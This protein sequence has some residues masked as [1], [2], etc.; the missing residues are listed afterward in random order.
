[1]KILRSAL[2]AFFIFSGGHSL[3]ALG[4]KTSSVQNDIS[5]LNAS[6]KATKSEVLYTVHEMVA[7]GNTIK[8]YST[9][10]GV[11][12]AVSWRG[13]SKPDLSVLF[14]S[15]YSEYMETLDEAPKQ[16]GKRNV[17]MKTPRM[18]VRRG[19]H[20]RDQRGFA[21]VPSLVPAGL[22]LEDLE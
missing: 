2:V 13:I 20:M 17:S 19:G 5:K 15:Y 16:P 22:K 11:V 10:D 21:H 14:G 6:Q 9:S 4:E 3:A 7:D 18:V 1:M 8:E 12:F